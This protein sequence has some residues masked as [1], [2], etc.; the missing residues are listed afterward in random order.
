MEKKLFKNKK[1]MEIK[2]HQILELTIYTCLAFLLMA[3]VLI[4][5]FYF[6]R[7]KI[8]EIEMSS[9]NSEMLH[10]KELVK[11]II[12]AQEEERKRIAQN[13][14]DDINSKL[15][16][17]SINSHLLKEKNLTDNEKTEIIN[18]IINYTQSVSE[19]S[20][21]IAHDLLPP[22]LQN[23]GLDAG[24]SE[25]CNELEQLKP[26]KINYK[27]QVK[28]DIKNCD[29]QLHL[30]RILQELLTNSIKHGK[31]KNISILFTVE[32]NNKQ[33]LYIDDGIGFDIKSLTTRKGL[34][35]K[36]IESRIH[37]LNG[38]MKMESALN[39]GVIFTLN[40]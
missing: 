11:A 6:S 12:L 21:R 36:N 18:T 30:F 8:T 22:V 35:L 17:I 19:D 5:F 4:L 23:F 13:L 20:R 39:E 26:L 3:L 16:I 31:A 34:G 40:F 9:Q 27:N 32:K 24:I 29:K 33:L 25:M 1:M 2:E 37:F 15:N 10:Q 28:F 7:K 38:N 14:H